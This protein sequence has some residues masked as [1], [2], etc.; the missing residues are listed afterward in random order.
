M[1]LDEEVKTISYE[2]KVLLAKATEILIYELT[3]RCWALM[4]PR[5]CKRVIMPIDLRTAASSDMMFDFLIDILPRDE[6]CN[7]L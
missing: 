7:K 2:A 5:K 1:K 4:Q 6:A 3:L